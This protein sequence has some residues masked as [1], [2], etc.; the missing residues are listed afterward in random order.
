VSG[1]TNIVDSLTIDVPDERHLTDNRTT[2]VKE[3]HFMRRKSMIGLAIL[4]MAIAVALGCGSD[5][6]EGGLVEDLGS[7]MPGEPE[8]PSVAET[9]PDNVEVLFADDLVHVS[10]I[11]LRSGESIPELES[12]PRLYYQPLGLAELSI[13]ND[14][15]I[16]MAELKSGEVRYVEPGA[17]TITNVAELPIEL[18]EVARTAVMLPEFLESRASEPAPNQQ[19]IFENDQVRVQE[20]TLDGG[21]TADLSSVPIRVVY[22]PSDSVLEYR[23]ADGETVPVSSGPSAAYSR[24]GDDLSVTNPGDETATVVI[25]EWLV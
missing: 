23:S 21:D 17:V 12:G 1:G 19:T 13:G 15:E 7:L 25:F 5:K 4:V 10:R 11:T 16:F 9:A 20:L 6:P 3:D 24:P 22:S 14:G 2:K 8:V 18:I